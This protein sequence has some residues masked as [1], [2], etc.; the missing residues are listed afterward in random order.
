MSRIERL[1]E[2][3]RP[4]DGPHGQSSHKGNIDYWSER[5]SA[6]SQIAPRAK[7]GP[8]KLPSTKVNV[9]DSSMKPKVSRNVD[10]LMAGKD[11]LNHAGD[12]S[13]LANVRRKA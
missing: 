4:L 2:Y 3:S 12:S 8:M 7:D 11:D 6:N 1:K 13:Y 9:R 5:A 10:R